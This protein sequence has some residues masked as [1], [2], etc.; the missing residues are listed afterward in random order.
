MEK[1]VVSREL[2][3]KLKDAGYPKKSTVLVWWRLVDSKRKGKQEWFLAKRTPMLEIKPY[4]IVAAPL[5]DELLEQLR[6]YDFEIKSLNHETLSLVSD[7]L[8]EP[9]AAI[10][11]KNF[12]EVLALLWLELNPNGHLVDKE[13]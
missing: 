5:S 7:S 2:A 13:T 3:Q 10:L 1:Y 6:N 4:E 12:A 11:G 8:D 9:D